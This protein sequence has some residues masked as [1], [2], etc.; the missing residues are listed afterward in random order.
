MGI[1]LSQEKGR[2]YYLIQDYEIFPCLPVDRVKA[3]YNLPLHKIVVSNWLGDVLREQFG[4][5]GTSVVQNAVDGNQFNALP[6]NKRPEPTVGFLYSPSPRKNSNA[7]IESLAEAKR[8]IPNLRAIS[9]GAAS[10]VAK[11]PEW[12]LFH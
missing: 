9:F 12:I 6:R 8:L 5:Q 2:K 1:Q 4:S 11:L 3:T 10:P 7:A